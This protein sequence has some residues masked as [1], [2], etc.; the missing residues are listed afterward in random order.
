MTDGTSA[1][2]AAIDRAGEAGDGGVLLIPRGSSRLRDTA[3]V[4]PGVRLIGDA[5]QRPVF[6]LS[7]QSPGF[8]RP[9]DKYVFFFSEGRGGGPGASPRDS[10]S[11][12]FSSA[13]GHID[14]DI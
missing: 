10:T 4:W 7:E 2:Q 12:T 6:R 9:E 8:Q 3:N 13:L 1:L 5:D 14:I 11:C